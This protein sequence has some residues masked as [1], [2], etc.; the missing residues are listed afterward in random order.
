[1]AN[2]E[3]YLAKP[4]LNSPRN[5]ANPGRQHDIPSIFWAR[6][7]AAGAL[8]DRA[9]GGRGGASDVELAA[10]GVIGAT[11]PA[12]SA[13]ALGAPAVAVDLA[14]RLYLAYACGSPAPA[15]APMYPGA[16]S[17]GVMWCGEGWE[18]RRCRRRR[19]RL[20]GRRRGWAVSGPRGGGQ[21]PMS[22][23]LWHDA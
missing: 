16:C 15:V 18:G 1:M 11:S 12:A 19:G 21:R 6:V 13:L 10:A 20:L 3:L 14:G 2:G 23:M 8:C 22:V 5:V 7:K 9:P 17:G 4:E